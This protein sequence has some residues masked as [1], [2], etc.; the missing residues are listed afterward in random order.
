MTLNVIG[1]VFCT[2]NQGKKYFEEKKFNEWFG[3]CSFF[4]SKY[5]IMLIVIC[6]YVVITR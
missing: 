2:K 6:I 5:P 3:E 4:T 1:S